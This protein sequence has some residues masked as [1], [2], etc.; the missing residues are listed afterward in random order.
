MAIPTDRD[1]FKETIL[2]RLGKGVIQINV[3]D[4]QVD[5]RVDFALAKFR[6]YHYDGTDQTYYK[7]AITQTDINNKYI[8]LPDNVVGAV[9]VFDLGST[10][11]G[12]GMFNAQYQFVLN[13]IWTWQSSSL[14]PYVSAMTH[15]SLIEQILVGQQPIRY[16]KFNNR[17]YLDTHWDRFTVGQYLIVEAFVT[18][19][20][21]TYMKIWADPWLQEYATQLVKQVWG[22]LLK[23]Y[24]GMQTAGNVQFSGQEIYDEAS[25]EILRLEAVLHTDY[26]LPPLF[27]VG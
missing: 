24:K 5:D 27:I 15:L 18:T 19:D 2:R 7:K 11:M 3:S 10:L 23:K 1:E 25:A 13:N 20:P 4:E 21:D 12:S 14:V 8:T 26:E 6:D 16:N 9:R 17:L 22:E